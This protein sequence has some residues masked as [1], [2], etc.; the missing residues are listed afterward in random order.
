MSKTERT[1]WIDWHDPYLDPES[2]LSRRLNVVQR[3]IQ[4]FLDG[5][6]SAAPRVISLCAG[7]GRDL[8]DLIAKDPRASQIRARRVE[9]RGF[10]RQRLCLFPENG[11]VDAHRDAYY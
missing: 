2:A 9:L 3:H 11:G 7:D 8:L 4:F 5:C 1:D 10:D 6:R